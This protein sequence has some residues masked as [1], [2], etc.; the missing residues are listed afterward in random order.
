[1]QFVKN[2]NL[3]SLSIVIPVYNSESCI[4]ELLTQLE[5]V[6]VLFDYEIILVDDKSIDKSWDILKHNF[7]IK[8][9]VSIIKLSK[10]FGQDSA[11][12]C[13]LHNAQKDYIIIM[14]DDLQHDPKYIP[15]LYNQIKETKNDV[16]FANFFTKNQTFI[17]NFG[18]WLNGKLA[19]IVIKKPRHIYL[20]P[21]KILS[22]NL[23]KKI[24]SYDG[25]YPYVDGLIFRYTRQTTQIN[26]NHNKRFSGKGNYSIAKSIS[27]WLKV[28]TNFSII[29]LRIATSI[30]I[31]SAFVG[32]T[33][34]LYF[35]YL[36][37]IGGIS[38]KGWSSLIVSVL[39]IGGV[40]LIA[41]GI[42][43]EYVGRSFLYQNKE[44]QYI[45][46]KAHL[47]ENN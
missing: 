8:T 32:F 43:G 24:L 2:K 7:Q 29:P 12:M 35:I 26:I 22:K 36:A 40:Q 1:M 25:P 10:N 31:L 45:I 17:K 13:G 38:L 44:P 18:S 5:K 19:N 20:S 37:I 28:L 16:C 9:N 15:E 41:L 34:G 6:L 27:V 30:G 14:D 4:Q 47:Y 21:F 33:M 46:D 23:V 11:I 3:N 42:I 39:F